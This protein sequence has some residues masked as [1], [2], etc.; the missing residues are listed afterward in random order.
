M[1]GG[2]RAMGGQ[3]SDGAPAAGG[4]GGKCGG[5]ALLVA[6]RAGLGLAQLAPPA[7]PVASGRVCRELDAGLRVLPHPHHVSRENQQ[8]LRWPQAL[9]PS[10]W[11]I[12]WAR[13]EVNG[14]SAGGRER[15]EKGVAGGVHE[16]VQAP[17]PQHPGEAR[18]WQCPH[19]FRASGS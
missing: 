14:D 10:S 1:L 4:Q 7:Q 17:R 15:S 11:E 9:V 16:R 3:E 8:D 13:Q 2:G 19:F 12:A 5:L 18:T 6:A